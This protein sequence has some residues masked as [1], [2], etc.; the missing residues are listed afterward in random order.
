M[1]LHER[2][3][4]EIICDQ[5]RSASCRAAAHGCAGMGRLGRYCFRWLFRTC[6]PRREQGRSGLSEVAKE[7]FPHG[8]VIPSP[9]LFPTLPHLV[10]AWQQ[11]GCITA[12]PG[13]KKGSLICS[14]SNGNRCTANDFLVCVLRLAM[15][16]GKLTLSDQPT[17]AVS[18][19]LPFKARK[20]ET[21]KPPIIE[22]NSA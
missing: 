13:M 11:L 16:P 5:A 9:T 20:L 19:Q 3:K 15:T 8:P 22:R 1:C 7:V 2:V 18:I 17:E 4:Q 12:K 21:T 6:G 14:Y 10:D